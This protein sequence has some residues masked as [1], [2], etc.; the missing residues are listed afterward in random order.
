MSAD[1]IA[2]RTLDRAP[3]SARPRTRVR[4]RRL[5]DGRHARRAGGS[6]AR[7][8]PR[9]DGRHLV[10]VA[11]LAGHATPTSTTRRAGSSR[12][13]AT[14]ASQ[15]GDAVAFQLPNW[16]EAVVSFA[17]LAMG[18]YVVVPIVHIYGRKEVAFILEQ[19]GAVAY[20]SPLAY[21]HVDYGAIVETAAPP[22]LRLHVV[23]DDAEIPPRSSGVARI[24]W[25][26][27]ADREAGDRPPGGASP[28]TSRCS[29]T[30]P[31]RPAIPRA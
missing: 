27:C 15:P 17:A 29:R 13:S 8:A 28:R 6:A 21:G 31:G 26:A 2:R 25:A 7:R 24:G 12:C 1:R 22:S 14:W 20:I 5:V 19:S 30:R 3:R 11:R 23:V 18:G 4:R 10:A 16:R 9:V